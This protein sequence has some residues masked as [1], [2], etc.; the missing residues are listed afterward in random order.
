MCSTKFGVN[1]KFLRDAIATRVETNKGKVPIDAGCVV[2][3]VEGLRPTGHDTIRFRV[4]GEATVLEMPSD[5]F[6][7]VTERI[8]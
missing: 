7:D 6:R 3:L 2:A 5:D 4:P 1:R 8:D